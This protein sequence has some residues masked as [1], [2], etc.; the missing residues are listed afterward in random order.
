MSARKH[1]LIQDL[2]G[3]RLSRRALGRRALSTGL[4]LG[5]AGAVPRFAANA[6][7]GSA[8]QDDVTLTFMHWGSVLEKE[9]LTEV[10][11][12]F[13]EANP[14]ITVEQQHI[15]D[16]YDTKLNTLVASNSLPDVFYISE[17]LAM[18][19]AEAGRIVD[20]TPHSE[21]L[22]FT[23]RMPQTFYYWAPGKTIGTMLAPEITLLFYNKELFDAAGVPY[24]PA[25]AASAYAWDAFVET[26]KLLTFDRNDRNAADP[27]FDPESVRQFGTTFASWWMSWYPL[28]RSNGG[29][30]ADEAGTTYT[31]NRP[32]AVEVFQNLQDLIHEHHVAPTPTQME[33]LPA[34]A[35]A[36]QTKRV[37]MTL[38]GQWNLLDIAAAGFE[39]GV[40][41]LPSYDTPVTVIVGNVVSI[42]AQTEHLEEALK[43]H[44]FLHDAESV[45][46]L[47]VQGLWMPLQERYYTDPQAIDSW[48][49]NEV[50]PP[51]YK[52]AAVDYMLN[53][54]VT[55]PIFIRD[56]ATINSRLEQGLDPVWTGDK[57]AQQALD[58]LEKEIQP[59]LKGRFATS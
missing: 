32:E 50:H 9:V 21:I 17:G 13:H 48:I 33:S 38:D 18:E 51:E 46:D 25:E 23:D 58:D 31:L 15:P 55:S 2:R 47:Q 49:A 10:I 7:A 20:L 59:L 22:G 35:Q 54:S 5:V 37:A 19:W 29:D 24:P 34:A 1:D 39:H 16:E 3:H 14:G 8:A 6:R 40:G 4:A 43:F 30:V 27:D 11:E 44:A 45:K 41:V 28:V 42:N 56:W 57:S 36:L 53:H 52:T 12:R 26:A